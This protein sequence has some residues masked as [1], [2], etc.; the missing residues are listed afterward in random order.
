MKASTLQAATVNPCLVAAAIALMQG[1]AAFMPGP[2][3]PV[4]KYSPPDPPPSA[5]EAQPGPDGA[6]SV[7]GKVRCAPGISS[8]A[9]RAL[10]VGSCRAA[11][12]TGWELADSPADIVGRRLRHALRAARQCSPVIDA[13][14]APRNAAQATLDCLIE[15]FHLERDNGKWFFSF[16]ASIV[17]SAPGDDIRCDMVSSRIEIAAQDGGEPEPDDVVRAIAQAIDSA[18]ARLWM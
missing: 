7:I 6:M 4:P 15:T 3:P 17:E 2:R 18:F 10:D 1:C 16:A 8:H 5:V 14:I 11:F 12:A 13:A 9:L